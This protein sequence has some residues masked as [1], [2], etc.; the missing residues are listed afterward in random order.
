MAQ[1]GDCKKS[2]TAP[3]NAII[4]IIISLSVRPALQKDIIDSS[5]R[6]SIHLHLHLG[7]VHPLQDVA[8]HQCLICKP[9][10]LFLSVL[11]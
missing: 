8:L 10:K 3:L 5:L 2:Q 9:K 7:F 6:F 1:Q 4:I 11:G